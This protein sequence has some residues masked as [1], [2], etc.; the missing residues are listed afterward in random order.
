MAQENARDADR[1]IELKAV[2]DLGLLKVPP[3]TY[4]LVFVKSAEGRAVLEDLVGRYHDAPIGE[5]PERTHTTARELGRRDVVGF[6]LRRLAQ[7]A[8]TQKG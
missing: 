3:E 7:I 5:D 4:H 6:I 1:A 2:Q 8:D